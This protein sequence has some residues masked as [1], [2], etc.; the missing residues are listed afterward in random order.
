MLTLYAAWVP[1]FTCEFYEV[2][3]NGEITLIETKKINPVEGNEITLPSYDEESGAFEIDGKLYDL[4][5]D[6]AC[7]TEK[8]DG[9]SVSHTG[10]FNAAN[11]TAENTV[12]K[13]Y[14]K[15]ID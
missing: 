14:C 15:P 6:D 13:I 2:G 5:L 9:T 11:A 7:A 1:D 12:M 8:L 10:T 4:Y 3:D